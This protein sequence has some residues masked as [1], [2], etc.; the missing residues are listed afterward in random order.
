MQKVTILILLLC[1]IHVTFGQKKKKKKEKNAE[2]TDEIVLDVEVSESSTYSID[3]GSKK[4]ISNDNIGYVTI[5][6]EYDF[7]YDKT[8]T[9]YYKKKYGIVSKDGEVLLP[10][11][12]KNYSKISNG[13]IKL[14]LGSKS[15]LY[16]VNEKKWNLELHL[17]DLKKVNYNT[18]IYQAK[19][20]GVW[21][22]L[23][24]SGNMISK[25]QWKTIKTI[26]GLNNYLITAI[27]SNGTT[28]YG[29]YSILEK[30]II[31]PYIYTSINQINNQNYFKVEKNGRFNIINIDNE[32][33]LTKW[34]DK[35]ITPSSGRNYYIVSINSKMGVINSK[36]EVIVP[37][38]YLEIGSTPYSDGSYL[39]KNSDGKYG[40]MRIDG[41][42]TL[43]FQ[44]DN[45][46]KVN[47]KS[48]FSV[49]GQ[50]CGLV[51]VNSGIP[52]EILTCDYDNVIQNTSDYSIIVEREGLFGIIDQYGDLITEV[53]YNSLEQIKTGNA[54]IYKGI[55]GEDYY[56]IDQQGQFIG[57]QSYKEID[58]IP[59][60]EKSSSYQ[61]S[62]SYFKAKT[63]DKYMVIDKIGKVISKEQFDDIAFEFKNFMVVKLNQKYA[64]YN[65]LNSQM[66]T[67]FDYDQI[68]YD[69][70]KFYA[71]KNNE[72]EQIQIKGQG[73]E[74]KIL[75]L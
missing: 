32:P 59:D 4:P 75:K 73:L 22:L 70:K 14:S 35:L 28:L 50:K 60:Y 36:E 57:D 29:I 52:T 30:K 1:S 37:I 18:D 21:G 44:Y 72:V 49:K 24:E 58:V 34:Y 53:K 69:D 17:Q 6:E 39:A 20:N 54:F 33:L 27:E 68:A 71:F 63:S 25:F 42:V 66:M 46:K 38:S 51:Q 47:Q 19:L 23:D 13:N 3:R 11:I 7:F 64:I 26:S 43:P 15:G 65:L 48:V 2:V 55:I 62:F 40:F 74:K 56:L 31:I 8:E 10:A 9:N 41:T 16:N 61:L 5:N 67:D 45:L 12:F